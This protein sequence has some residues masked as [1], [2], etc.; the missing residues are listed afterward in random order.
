M[1]T[2]GFLKR[3]QG[4]DATTKRR[5]LIAGSAVAMVVV[6]YVWLVYFN[7]LLADAGGARTAGAGEETGAS[8]WATMRR[9]SAVLYDNVADAFG[10]I[11]ELL[12]GSRE[13]IVK[14]MK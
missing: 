4:A 12:K 8:F 7:N 1:N 9:G 13:Y 5:V 10:R 6:L 2:E 14:P 3:L 11:G